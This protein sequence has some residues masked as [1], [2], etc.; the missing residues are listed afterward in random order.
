MLDVRR[1][2]KCNPFLDRER[3]KIFVVSRLPLPFLCYLEGVSSKAEQDYEE[4]VSS[5]DWTVNVW[6]T[7]DTLFFC[8]HSLSHVSCFLCPIWLLE[9]KRTVWVI[10]VGDREWKWKWESGVYVRLH[11]LSLSS[12]ADAS[13]VFQECSFFCLFSWCPRKNFIR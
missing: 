2:M 6:T 12:F 9:I 10:R 4:T 7:L 3:K 8:L 5:L 13:T 1:C 11:P